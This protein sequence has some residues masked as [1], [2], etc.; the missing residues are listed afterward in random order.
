[1]TLDRRKFLENFGAAGAGICAFG[2]GLAGVSTHTR[3]AG[4]IVCRFIDASTRHP[5]PVRVR[6]VDSRGEN[7]IPL[8]HP[9][10]LAEEAPEGDVRFQSLRFAYS[11]G[12][13]RFDA[14]RLPIRYQAIKGYE[15]VIA[16]GEIRAD[17][18]QDGV[19]EVALS[20]WSNASGQG[21]YSGDIHIHHISPQT[22]R[23]E[24]DAEDLNVA[25]ILTSDFTTDQAQFEGKL[26]SYSGGKHLVYVNQEFRVRDKGMGEEVVLKEPGTVLVEA[27]VPNDP[28]RDDLKRLEVVQNGSDL[29]S[30]PTIPV[31]PFH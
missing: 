23:L 5:V 7:V 21:W 14:D 19:T 29:P 13:F 15:Y 10:R 11:G 25:N 3:H 16:E 18:I 22:C 4:P 31:S 17:N 30:P 26:S 9:E 27:R 28:A 8:G 20:R 24:M 2:E 12:E 1:M 6:F